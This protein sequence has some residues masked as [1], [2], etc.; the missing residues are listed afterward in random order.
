MMEI[1]LK[2]GLI[3]LAIA[4][5]VGPIGLLCIRRTLRDGRL[6][7]LATGLGAATAD[8]FYGLVAATGLAVSGLLISHGD[9]MRIGGGLLILY[10]GI[11]TFRRGLD[12]Q[13]HDPAKAPA[14]H[15]PLKAYGTTFLLTLSNP[16]TILAFVGMI[17]GL[18]VGAAAGKGAAYWLVF[19]VFSGSALWW[20]FL[21]SMTAMMRHFVSDGLMRMIDFLS[22]AILA[23]W[24]AWMAWQGSSA[25][26]LW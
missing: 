16:S 11:A 10:L 18:T 17:S 14:G 1:F 13:P 20:L 19:G 9:W 25:L 7:G 22:G 8:G 2:G 4:A 5:P 23:V 21:V 3:G 26:S 6:V 15:A 24:G 12:V